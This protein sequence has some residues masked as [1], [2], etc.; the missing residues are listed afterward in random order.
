MRTIHMLF[1]SEIRNDAYAL[2][3]PADVAGKNHPSYKG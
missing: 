1:D 2:L 3:P